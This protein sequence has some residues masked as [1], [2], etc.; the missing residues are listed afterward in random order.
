MAFSFHVAARADL[1]KVHYS[2]A[3]EKHAR[4]FSFFSFFSFDF[5]FCFGLKGGE[6]LKKHQAA[7]AGR[8]FD[9]SV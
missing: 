9:S 3:P 1:P 7:P 8:M 6:L 4:E 2:L 5:F